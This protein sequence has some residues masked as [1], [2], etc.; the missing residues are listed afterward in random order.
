MLIQEVEKTFSNV[1]ADL[2]AVR[3]GWGGGGVGLNQM[4][5]LFRLFFFLLLNFALYIVLFY[6]KKT[7][8]LGHQNTATVM[9]HYPKNG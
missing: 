2:L 4:T 1:G 8:M 3:V 7:K 9:N 5:F 6:S